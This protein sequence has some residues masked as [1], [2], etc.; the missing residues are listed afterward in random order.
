MTTPP[1]AP[2]PRRL[3][4]WVIGVWA[5]VQLVLLAGA[6]GGAW[7]WPWGMFSGPPSWY[8]EPMVHVDAGHGW[9]VLPMAE[10][11]GYTEGFTRRPIWWTH[12]GL[13][14][15]DPE[16]LE[17][18]AHHLGEVARGLHGDDVRAVRVAIRRFTPDGYH[19]R[20]DRLGVFEV[21]P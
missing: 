18:W 13:K 10:W 21:G 3:G 1:D 16:A 15:R 8:D 19:L 17:G 2:S 20:D 4:R 11:V 7:Q 14:G 6:F 5:A 12:P 9:V